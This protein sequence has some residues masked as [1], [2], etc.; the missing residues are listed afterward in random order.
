MRS[1]G[2]EQAADS[3]HGAPQVRA[4]LRGEGSEEA[5]A[6]RSG[7]GR[8]RGGKEDGAIRWEW[9]WRMRE[10]RNS[11]FSSRRIERTRAGTEEGRTC[12]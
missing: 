1:E 4:A 3:G 5:A 7:G 2:S 9:D 8:G 6:A 11:H 12:V 10:G